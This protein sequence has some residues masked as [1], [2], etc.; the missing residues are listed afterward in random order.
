MKSQEREELIW[1]MVE[2]DLNLMDE[3]DIRSRLVYMLVRHK[4]APLDDD[5]LMNEYVERFPE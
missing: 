5:E 4:Y 3:D 1:K 2:D